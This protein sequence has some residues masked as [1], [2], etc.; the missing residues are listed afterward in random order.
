MEVSLSQTGDCPQKLLLKLAG[1]LPLSVIKAVSHEQWCHPWLRRRFDNCAARLRNQDGTI[2]QGAGKGLRFNPG[3][4]NAGYL[5]STAE[6]EVQQALKMIVVPG[7]VVYDLG[8]NVGFVTVI[9]ASLVGPS[10]R[11]V[12]FEPVP[13]NF[14]WL[15]HNVRLNGFSQ[16]LIR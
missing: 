14:Q 7:T 8:A 5:L 6:P 16:V 2:Q 15:Q 11:V 12:A 3:C 4:A 9:A 10:G 1:I 13:D